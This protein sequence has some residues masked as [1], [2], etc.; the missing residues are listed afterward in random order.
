MPIAEVFTEPRTSSR[1]VSVLLNAP[2]RN[3]ADFLRHFIEFER[4]GAVSN[5][6]SGDLGRLD[7]TSILVCTQEAVTADFLTGLKSFLEDQPAW[8]QLPILLMLDTEFMSSRQVLGLRAEL[9]K[10]VLVMLERPAKRIEISSAVRSLIDTRYRQLEIRDHLAYQSELHRELDHRLKN[11][12]AT[13]MAVYRMTIRQSDDLADFKKTFDGRAH[14][15]VSVQDMLRQADTEDHTVGQLCRRVLAPYLDPNADQLKLVNLDVLIAT[16]KSF[17]LS[18]ILNELA[19]NAV[20]YGALSTSDGQIHLACD[21][22]DDTL[23]QLIW[24]EEGGPLVVQPESESYGTRFI[25]ASAINLG[26]GAVFD[27]RPSGLV[28]TLTFRAQPSAG[29][30]PQVR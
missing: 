10:S 19:T 6:A 24:R 8:A 27:Y 15:L 1:D 11:T 7:H 16:D 17:L 28:C 5:L 29:S 26:G 12:L 3:D 14:A 20:K 13:F 22:R 25:N 30:E 9:R 23:L 18:L 21:E 4:I 2:Y